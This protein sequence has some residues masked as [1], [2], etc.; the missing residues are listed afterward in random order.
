MSSFA[1]AFNITGYCVESLQSSS[2]HAL[3]SI[4]LIAEVL[5]IC[6]YQPEFCMFAP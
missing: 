4:N 6:I 1:V 3:Q 5:N 2:W